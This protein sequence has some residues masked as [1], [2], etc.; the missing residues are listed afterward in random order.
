MPRRSHATRVAVT[1]LAGAVAAVGLTGAPATAATQLPQ[2]RQVTPFKAGAA[3]STVVHIKMYRSS[4]A[5]ASFAEP[6]VI[7]CNSG[8]NAPSL[9]GSQVE[10]EAVAT[11]DAPVNNIKVS[12]VIVRDNSVVGN[13]STT[14]AS[15]ATRNDA[16]GRMPCAGGQHLYH[17][18][19]LAVFTPPPNYTPPEIKQTG[20]S[21]FV[22][23]SC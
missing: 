11:C 4:R 12:A 5:P 18:A 3:K 1:A 21:G 10:A 23:I 2:E 15:S 16:F 8:V 14:E 17:S 9:R 22:S 20:T 19:W 6:P 13:I 7:N